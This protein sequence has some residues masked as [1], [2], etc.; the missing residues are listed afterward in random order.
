[1]F[2]FCPLQPQL[3]GIHMSTVTEKR[4]YFP[5]IELRVH[6]DHKSFMGQNVMLAISIELLKL[7]PLQSFPDLTMIDI[8]AMHFASIK[9]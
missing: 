1:M 3:L 2:V 5:R 4:E 7:F 8:L 6:V 9:I